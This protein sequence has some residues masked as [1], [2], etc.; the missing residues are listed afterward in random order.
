MNSTTNSNNNG[1]PK[2]SD[3]TTRR[4]RNGWGGV[5]AVVL[6]FAILHLWL[7]FT[8]DKLG[9]VIGG[10]CLLAITAIL[11]AAPRTGEVNQR[12]D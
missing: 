6:A 1:E 3:T 9:Y 11:L 7:G 12:P 2:V 4:R 5:A 10:T 8:T